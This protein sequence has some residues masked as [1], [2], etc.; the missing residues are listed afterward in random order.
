MVYIIYDKSFR[1][2]NIKR[3]RKRKIVE[4]F[5]NFNFLIL[6]NVWYIEEVDNLL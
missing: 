6:L 1:F 4:S 5:I 2:L 3:K